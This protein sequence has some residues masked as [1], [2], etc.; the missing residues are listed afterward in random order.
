[1]CKKLIVIAEKEEL[2]LVDKLNLK[3]IPVLITGVG[4]MNVIGALR[5][6]SRDTEIIN[7]G[8]AG[9]KNLN[10]N[11]FFEVRNVTL[12]HPNVDYAE[13]VYHCNEIFDDFM[14]RDCYSG[15]DF[16]LKTDKE[17]CL[18]DMELGYIVSLGFEKV[19]SVKYVSDNLDLVEY[20]KKLS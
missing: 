20:R 13:P 19:S 11:E 4:A 6:I 1:M 16:V 9:S 7:V 17:D 18:F 2:K 10:P 8:Y 12:Y 15:S 14:S 5:N 3:G